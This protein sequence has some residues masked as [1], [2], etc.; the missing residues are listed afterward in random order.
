MNILSDTYPIRIHNQCTDI[1]IRILDGTVY[2][3]DPD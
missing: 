1:L 3:F 2:C